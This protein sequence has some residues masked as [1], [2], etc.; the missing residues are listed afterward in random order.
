M[1]LSGKSRREK[2]VFLCDTKCS[3]ENSKL[4]CGYYEEISSVGA[5]FLRSASTRT[6]ELDCALVCIF[7]II[8]TG[9]VC[10]RFS[11]LRT[12]L[13]GPRMLH[14]G[15]SNTINEPIEAHALNATQSAHQINSGPSHRISYLG[16][17]DTCVGI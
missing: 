12:I 2:V 4:A 1:E 5:Y 17:F 16:M 15:L 11:M 9:D 14:S 3:L 6:I 13:W 7:R 8:W 10:R